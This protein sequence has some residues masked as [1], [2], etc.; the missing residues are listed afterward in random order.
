M[1]G[2]R[3][4]LAPSGAYWCL[5]ALTAAY[6]RLLPLTGAYLYRPVAPV[7]FNRASSQIPGRVLRWYLAYRCDQR[8]FWMSLAPIAARCVR[9]SARIHLPR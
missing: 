7:C 3:L 5:L 9:K 4:P 6:W 8:V 2:F 1:L